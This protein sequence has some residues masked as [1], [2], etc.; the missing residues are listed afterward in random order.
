MSTVDA[1]VASD[2]SKPTSPTTVRTPTIAILGGTGLLGR[3]LTRRLMAHSE[4][5]VILCCRHEDQARAQAVELAPPEAP[6]RIEVR[7]AD[8]ANP[9]D[10][11]E[12]ARGADWLVI[13]VDTAQHLES[14]IEGA[15]AARVH[16]L[17]LLIEPG[18]SKVW[19]RYR[20]RFEEAGR[21][22]IT[23]AGVQPGLPGV[24]LE[25]LTVDRPPPTW[26]D[27]ASTLRIRIPDDLPMP[28]STV[29]LIETF[30]ERPTVYFFG[31]P[32]TDVPSYIMPYRFYWFRAPFRRQTVAVMKL[33][34][35]AAFAAR[36]P[37][38]RR[39]R[40]MVG[41]FNGFATWFAIPVL[42][43]F[44]L[45]FG[46]WLR[47]F[48]ARLLYYGALRPF[49]RPPFGVAMRAELKGP[50]KDRASL[51]LHH[52]EEYGLTAD[53][54]TALIDATTRQPPEAGV[55][56][57]ADAVDA[58]AFVDRLELLGARVYWA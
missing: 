49:C 48:F 1:G 23:E 16:C 41:G 6:E 5:R 8:A 7:R 46:R 26:L 54:V 22:V 21:C 18:R 2:A 35:V 45:L 14:I 33:P 57:M 13:A 27:L 28:A 17:D 19:N 12:A 37:K 32:T 20:E 56:M 55:H 9:T 25:A 3:E 47:P 44:L 42:L 50:G 24:L 39:V 15:L 34:E 36:H 53:V 38:I 43:P 4:S 58:R 10:V 51:E 52:D 11:A 40:Y 31:H 30:T 29:A